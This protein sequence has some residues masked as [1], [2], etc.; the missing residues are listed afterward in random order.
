MEL[1]EKGRMAQSVSAGILYIQGRGFKSLSVHFR[2]GCTALTVG[3]ITTELHIILYSKVVARI[4]LYKHTKLYK[5]EA[6]RDT[7]LYVDTAL[8]LIFI[9]CVLLKKIQNYIDIQ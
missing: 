6:A 5:V 9:L 8:G 1:Q 7:A 4:E 3:E 2:D